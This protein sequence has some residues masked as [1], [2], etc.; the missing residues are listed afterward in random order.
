[1]QEYDVL[2]PG[3]VEA[4]IPSVPGFDSDTVIPAA[5]AQQFFRGGYKFC[6]RYLSLREQS[7]RDLTTQEAT[8]I[9]NA[10]LALMPVQHVRQPGWLPT[11]SLGQRDGQNAASNAQDVGFPPGVNVWCDLEGVRNGASTQDVT[12]YCEAWH[13]AVSAAGYAPGLYV[14]SAARLSGEQLFALSFQHYWRSQSSVPEIPNRGYQLIQLF[15]S[16][17]AHGIAIDLDVTQADNRGGQAQWLRF[18]T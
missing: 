18:A 12:D 6:I 3:S 14:G 13:S 9:L 4:S 7:A 5:V 15:P 10:G 2:L 11:A 16:V 17:T 1:M 8:E